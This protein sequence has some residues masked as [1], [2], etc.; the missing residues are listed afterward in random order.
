M[1]IP[2]DSLIER[3][4]QFQ[5]EAREEGAEVS[6]T[7]EEIRSWTEVDVFFN[8]SF[9]L[10]MEYRP[11][12]GRPIRYQVAIPAAEFEALRS[13]SKA[14]YDRV[15]MEA[16]SLWHSIKSHLEENDEEAHDEGTSPAS[17]RI[18]D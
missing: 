16:Q 11:A 12:E 13:D 9:I 10:S 14:T 5:E 3:F 4:A 7:P 1:S 18:G 17:D 8:P 2:D 6:P 15:A